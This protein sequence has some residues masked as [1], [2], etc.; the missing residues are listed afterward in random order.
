MSGHTPGPWECTNE[1]SAHL[2]GYV[3][4]K[5]DIEIACAWTKSDALLIAAAPDLLEALKDL[6]TWWENWM[7]DEAHEQGGRDSLESARAAI[8]KSEGKT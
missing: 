4:C 2:P 8:A 3:V 7:P 1:G 6:A 5:E